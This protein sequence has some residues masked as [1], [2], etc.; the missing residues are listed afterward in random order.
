MP[1]F[2]ELRRINPDFPSDDKTNY[3]TIDILVNQHNIMDQRTIYQSCRE[4]PIEVI[5]Y[6]ITNWDESV[7]D[8]VNSTT[9]DL[10]IPKISD[11]QLIWLADL[12]YDKYESECMRYWRDISCSL[13]SGCNVH[14]AAYLL[15]K[16][17]P[18]E[19]DASH[20]LEVLI[21]DGNIDILKLL[22]AVSKEELHT[23][24]WP[25]LA[26]VAIKHKQR[27]IAQYI[28]DQDDPEEFREIQANLNRA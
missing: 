28:I 6:Y 22:Y 11:I 25:K 27:E 5:I 3:D 16:Y 26:S 1:E 4:Y 21:M 7:L 17:I 10:C 19:R 12:L 2:N 18:G 24:D 14:V 8:Y 13:F 9:L 15:S 23:I 20:I